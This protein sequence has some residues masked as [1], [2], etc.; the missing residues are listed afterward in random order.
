VS[1]KELIEMKTILFF[2]FTVLS[3]SAQYQL[4][5]SVVV[6]GGGHLTGG[7]YSGTTT[8]GQPAAGGFLTGG[9]SVHYS[10]FWSPEF[11]PT[12]AGVSISGR[13]LASSGV[14]LTN[15]TV[16]LTGQSG[17]TFV[18]RTSSFGNYHFNSVEIGQTVIISVSS[19]RYVYAPRTL[20]LQENV[21]DVDF[22]PIDS[23]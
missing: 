3:V 19:K 16:H 22:L 1:V 21:T 8:I 17:E 4:E 20:S 10:G 9:P 15:A 13:V 5:R 11:A 7:T 18:V 2:F 12:A 6:I 14:G 23:R